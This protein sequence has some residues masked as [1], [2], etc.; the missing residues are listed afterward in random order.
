M[1]YTTK[2]PKTG[3]IGMLFSIAGYELGIENIATVLAIFLISASLYTFYR[4]KKGENT[5]E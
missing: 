4:L 5:D 3:A 1:H 2:L